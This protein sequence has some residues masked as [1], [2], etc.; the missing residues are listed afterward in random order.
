MRFLQIVTSYPPSK[1][2]VPLLQEQ[3]A[4]KFLRDPEIGPVLSAKYGNNVK[5]EFFQDL[6]SVLSKKS[7][8]G[9][10]MSF[11]DW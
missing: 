10:L 7:I 4:K 1:L 9:H 11:F 5:E 2:G 3:I 8:S 6:S